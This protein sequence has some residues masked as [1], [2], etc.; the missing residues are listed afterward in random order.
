MTQLAPLVSSCWL[1]GILIDKNNQRQGYGYKAIQTAITKLSGE[2]GY[3]NFA[4]SY[5]PENP[6]KHLYK[7]LGFTE[8]NEWEENEV[9]ARLSLAK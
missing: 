2:H 4:L 3:Q 7:K 9:V 8:T 6:A 1:G 5:S